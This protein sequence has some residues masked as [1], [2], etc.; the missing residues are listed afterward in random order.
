MT[1]LSEPDLK[2]S[3]FAGACSEEAVVSG[4][5]VVA[6]ERKPCKQELLRI[7][8]YSTC[9]TLYTTVAEKREPLI[10]LEH[11]HPGTIIIPGR[12]LLCQAR[13]ENIKATTAKYVAV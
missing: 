7:L 1:Y 6:P 9:R 13:K 2:G 5:F 11:R 12:K 4:F 3:Y 10:Q 8:I